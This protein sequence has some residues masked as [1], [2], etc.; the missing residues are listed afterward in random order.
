MVVNGWQGLT[1]VD[2]WRSIAHLGHTWGTPGAHLGT[3]LTQA[4]LVVNP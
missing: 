2:Q 3:P 4:S 1:Y